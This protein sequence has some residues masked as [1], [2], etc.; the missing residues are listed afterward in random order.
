M[1][2]P[3]PVLANRNGHTARQKPFT[4]LPCPTNNSLKVHL[5]D[6]LEDGTRRGVRSSPCPWQILGW[7]LSREARLSPFSSRPI[8]GTTR[9][10]SKLAALQFW[11]LTNQGGRIEYLQ[12]SVRRTALQANI[13]KCLFGVFFLD[14]CLSDILWALCIVIVVFLLCLHQSL[15]TVP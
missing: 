10:R 3:H 12:Y 14:G 5:Q 4:R 11:T 2:I 6:S 9:F 8:P 15:R 13:E 7:M 1:L